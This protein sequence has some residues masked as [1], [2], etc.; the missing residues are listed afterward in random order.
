MA[1]FGRCVVVRRLHRLVRHGQ[2]TGGAQGV[3][4]DDRVEVGQPFGEEAGVPSG[5]GG[6]A[7]S[8]RS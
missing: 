3:P 4:G 2:N 7:V 5:E 6:R 1:P 8:R